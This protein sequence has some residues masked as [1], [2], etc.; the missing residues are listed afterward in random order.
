MEESGDILDQNEVVLQVIT[1]A[2]GAE[3][4]KKGIILSIVEDVELVLNG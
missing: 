1:T 4:V 3:E 2:S